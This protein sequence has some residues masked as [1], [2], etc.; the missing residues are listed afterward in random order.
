MNVLVSG[1]GGFIG[2]HLVRFLAQNAKFRHIYAIDKADTSELFRGFDKVHCIEVNL[3]S[4]SCHTELPEEIDLVFALAA[5][6]GTSRFYSTPVDVFENSLLPTLHLLRKY[7]SYANFVYS[8]SSEVYAGAVESHLVKVPTSE[9]VPLIVSDPS[10]PRWSY[11]TAKMAGE[12]LVHNTAS[13]YGTSAAIV[14]YHNVYG[15]EMG[16]DHFIPD[17]IDRAR[18]GIFEV[19]GG[20]ESR[21]FLFIEDA[22]KGTL[23]ASQACSRNVSVF[24]LGTDEEL[25]I[26]DAAKKILGI[27]GLNPSEINLLS[28][29]PGSVKRRIPDTRKAREVLGWTPQVKF[30][31]GIVR[32]LNSLN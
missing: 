25:K 12:V 22:V 9:K 26:I 27:M 31:E 5:L 14:R 15:P 28:S 7:R 23:L 1:A 8:S 24:H 10:N 18:K 32:F 30:E 21:S 16:F 19:I 6:N 20:D 3:S 29:R 2:R 11:S 13:Q 4:E 17:F